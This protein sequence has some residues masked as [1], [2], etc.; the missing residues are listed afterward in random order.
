MIDINKW[1]YDEFEQVGK[2]YSSNNEVAV[3]E[4]THS[5]FRDLVLESNEFLDVLSVKAGESLIDFGCGTGVFTIQAALRGVN[6]FAVDISQNML[7]YAEKKA[8]EKNIQ[9]ISFINSGFLNYTHS[10]ELV[11]YIMTSFSFHHLPDFWKAVA[12]K[13]MHSMLNSSGVLY[14]QDLVISEE[15]CINNINSF[16]QSQEELGGDFLRVDAIDHFRDEFS[17]YGWVIEEMLK[18]AGFKIES[19]ESFSGLICRYKCTKEED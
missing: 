13:R 3:Y 8:L 16:I 1:R 17:T 18:R 14:I 12:L 4:E 2:D 19:K 7:A 11:D 15:N 9:S 10:S 5:T 6:V